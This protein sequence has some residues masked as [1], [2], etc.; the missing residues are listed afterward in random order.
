[1]DAEIIGGKG[2]GGDIGMGVWR[3]KEQKEQHRRNTIEGWNGKKAAVGE[4]SELSRGW[5]R[6]GSKK[7]WDRK[8]RRSRMCGGTEG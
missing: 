3:R 6:G 8:G 7:E 2:G 1:M 4:G 5:N